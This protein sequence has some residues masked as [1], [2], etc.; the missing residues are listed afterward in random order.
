MLNVSWDR[1]LPKRREACC[2]TAQIRDLNFVQNDV[3]SGAAVWYNKD[4]NEGK[5]NTPRYRPLFA[6]RPIPTTDMTVRETTDRKAANHLGQLV[7]A[8]GRFC[9]TVYKKGGHANVEL[10][11]KLK[12]YFIIKK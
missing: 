2:E 6:R 3:D 12:L 5:M 9:F 11:P 1:I 10:S 4:V 8:I 7:R